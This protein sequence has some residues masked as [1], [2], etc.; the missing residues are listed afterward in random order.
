MKACRSEGGITPLIAA[1]A[2]DDA[3][4]VFLLLQAGADPALE[5]QNRTNAL[6][7]A[8]GQAVMYLLLGAKFP[9]AAGTAPEALH[10]LNERVPPSYRHGPSNQT[11]LTRAIAG[12]SFGDGFWLSPP[13]PPPVPSPR[14]PAV[15]S[16]PSVRRSDRVERVGVLL[17]LG[18]DPNQRLS[19]EGVDWTPLG[20]GVASRDVHVAEKLLAYGADANARWCVPIEF[21]KAT[22]RSKAPSQCTRESGVTPLMFA[23]SLGDAD[24]IRLLLNAG[25]DRQLQDWEAKTASAYAAMSK[26][27]DLADMLR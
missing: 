12:H 26:K 17:S 4:V 9:P 14:S 2:H 21:V 15:P 27:R 16:R 6:D 5:A 19:W 22:E 10:Y 18:A 20:L 25:A 23:A 3:E 8:H 1:A 11:A 24:M 7:H 13:P